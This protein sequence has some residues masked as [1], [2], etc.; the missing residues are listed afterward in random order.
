MST[1]RVLL[2]VLVAM[3]ASLLFTV[4]V[5][6]AA[7]SGTVFLDMDTVTHQPPMV[8]KDPKDKDNKEKVASGSVEL[9][10]GKFGKACKFTFVGSG[11]AI[12]PGGKIT[13]SPDWDQTDGFSFY[14]KGDGSESWGGIELADDSLAKRFGFCFPINSTEWTKITVPWKA[15]MPEIKGAIVDVK[16]GM[17]PSEFK[18]IQVGKW[19]Y[20]G[21]YPACSYSLDNFAIEKKIDVDATDYTAAST[22]LSR[23]AGKIKAGKPIT[24]VTMG[25]S[26]SDKKHWANRE[27]LWSEV[28]VKQLQEKHQ[29]KATLVNPA[30]GGTTLAQNII[31]MPR[32]EKL[33]PTPDL[34][35]V[36]FGGN[37]F[38]NGV[39]GAD[40]KSYLR[41]AVDRIRRDTKGQADILLVS[42]L[43]GFEKWDD[44]K[45]LVQA[46]RDVA[47]EKKVGLLDMQA[48]FHKAGTAEDAQKRGYWAKDNVHLGKAGHELFAQSVLNTLEAAK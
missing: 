20:W 7:E 25:D 8:A 41:E 42:T 45:D 17:K 14:V 35:V 9:V 33:A 30:I 47:A 40:M 2:V 27:V 10:D 32:W 23:V 24:L 3:I 5:A 1:P 31:T 44:Y 18:Y 12:F 16:A 19:Y 36:C 39:S 15:L 46:Y 4:P 38:D 22:G 28:L 21:T 48:E 43:P 29:C 26:L 37:D 6:R 13:P 34:V 11:P